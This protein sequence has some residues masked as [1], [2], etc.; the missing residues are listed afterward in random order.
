MK[1]I[2]NWIM[3][4]TAVFAVSI[5]T[6]NAAKAQ[7]GVSVSFNVFYDNLSPYGDW[8]QD[9]AYGYVWVPR[10]GA[11][12]RPYYTDGYWVMTEYGNTWVSDYAWGWAPFHYG[13]WTY[14]NWY[15]WVW[16][17]GNTWGPAWVSW[18]T[19][20][21]YYGWAPLGPGVS[22]TYVSYSP[23]VDWWVFI[24][25][26]YIH[27]R[28]FHNHYHGPRNN[29][30]IINNTTVI[31]NTFVNNNTTYVSGPRRGDI[32]RTTQQKVTVYDVNNT[33]KPG[34]ESVQNNKVTTY[35][36]QISA[37]NKT[38]APR[39]VEKAAQPVGKA[40]AVG[41]GTPQRNIQAQPSKTNM[42][43]NNANLRDSYN[44]GR[45]VN[46]NSTPQ[47]KTNV[48]APAKVTAPSN[49]APQ[50]TQ[51]SRE[52][53]RTNPSNTTPAPR[54]DV[55]RI[56]QQQRIQQPSTPQKIQPSTPQQKMNTQPSQKMGTNPY[57]QR[58]QQ[59]PNIQR[60]APVQQSPNMQRSAPVQQNKPMPNGGSGGKPSMRGGQ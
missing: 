50:R 12:F 34:K 51:P 15:G 30:T 46:I 4:L 48:Q 53:Q 19:S 21:S 26:R 3:I 9:P 20:S 23:P 2:K 37:S 58:I 8:I 10:V 16:I 13:R 55:N 59:S 43:S 27:D 33:G 40:S 54:N 22:V 28:H 31:N 18:R 35:R 39:T 6:T 42:N 32:E 24:P 29:T 1:S 44:N 7:A 52:I 38:A 60:S 57:Q 36:P 49:T 45:K 5:A 47:P 17:P 56:P 41:N 11:G 14:D 25:P